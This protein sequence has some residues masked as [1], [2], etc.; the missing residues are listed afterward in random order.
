MGAKKIFLLFWTCSTSP[1]IFSQTIHGTITDAES[2]KP[3]EYANVFL[4]NTLTGTVTD[5]E[6]S[7]ELTGFDP[8]KYDLTISFIGYKTFTRSLEIN[9]NDELEVNGKLTVEVVSLPEV[10]VTADTSNWQDDFQVF[11]A[12]F[13]GTTPASD[14]CSILNARALYFYYDRDENIL[15]AHA[16]EPLEIINDWLGYRITYD[17][18][19]FQ[20][21]F[22]SGRLAFYGVPRFSYL[23]SKNKST[24]RKWGRNREEAYKGSLLH[25][26]RSLNNLSLKSEQY[27]VQELIRLS[28]PDRPPSDILEK[29]ISSFRK[30]IREQQGSEVSLSSPL[31]DSLQYYL[32][33]KRQ[34]EYID[35]LGMKYTSG[36]ALMQNGELA[37]R[38]ILHVTFLGAREHRLYP[39]RRAGYGPGY[40]QSKLY[41]DEPL[42][43]YANGYFEDVRYSYVE[44]YWNWT[45]K[46]ASILPLDYYP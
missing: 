39:F 1:F 41:I 34:P 32:D 40:Q 13:L 16:R 18:Q 21:D 9:A 10:F 33:L 6:G 4:A 11:K 42:R 25:F 35:S 26:F 37:F 14:M 27:E 45:G 29:K 2:G 22:R 5:A 8:G 24:L 15:F 43:V 7:Y 30:K 38:G 3:V 44:G 46:M 31:T 19:S 28:N 17:M 12:N 36:H 20:L 23:K